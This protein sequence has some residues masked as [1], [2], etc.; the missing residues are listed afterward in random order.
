MCTWYA[1]MPQEVHW[2]VPKDNLIF[3]FAGKESKFFFKCF[4]K[5]AEIGKTNSVGGLLYVCL[6]AFNPLFCLMQT[7]VIVKFVQFH[8]IHLLE[9]S[10]E[11]GA[12]HE[13][14]AGKILY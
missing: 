9:T 11:F 13:G 8:T 12:A 14:N 2:V 1:L 7:I 3:Q 10:F 4:G 6:T 5:I